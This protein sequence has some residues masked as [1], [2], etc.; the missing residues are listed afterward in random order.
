ML[1]TF[2]SKLNIRVLLL[3]LFI[4]VTGISSGIFFAGLLPPADKSALISTL[5]N[6]D[7]S[8]FS[9]RLLTN[10]CLLLLIGFA[11][12]TVYGFPLAL[13]LLFFRGFSTGFCDCLLLYNINTDGVFSFL[14]SFLLPQLCLCAAYW[15]VSAFSTSY[16]LVKIRE[17]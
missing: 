9:L 17:R 3:C 12:F 5:A 15:A 7:T 8:P 10:L 4:L 14:F 1:N 13:F 11:G 6:A 16:A 2:F